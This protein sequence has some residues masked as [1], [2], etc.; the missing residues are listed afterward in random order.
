MSGT[1]IGLWLAAGA[2]LAQAPRIVLA[3]LAADRADVPAA[4]A[5]ALLVLAGLGTA[6]TLA[7]GSIYVAWATA[8]TRS[9]ALLAVWVSL[10]AA[11]AGLVAPSLVSGLAGSTLPAVLGASWQRWAWS[12]LAVVAHELV[13]AAALLSAVAVVPAG[14]GQE[15]AADAEIECR[16][17]CGRRFA[18][19]PA[20][21]AHL[22]HCGLRPG[23]DAR[24]VGQ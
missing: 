10:L 5:G 2:L 19:A 14:A 1:R 17:G 8:R 11:T 3:Y 20:E 16:F 13:A 18:S 22:R 15:P 4:I 21:R 7:G 12:V 9:R 6:A 24:D 23:V